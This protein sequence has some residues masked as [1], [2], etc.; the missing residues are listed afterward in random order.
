MV[1]SKLDSV[2]GE[3]PHRAL[4][5]AGTHLH[6][7]GHVCCGAGPAWRASLGISASSSCCSC[8]ELCSWSPQSEQLSTTPLHRAV[9]T[10]EQETVDGDHGLRPLR[11]WAR[12]PTSYSKVLW[13]VW[14]PSCGKLANT[15]GSPRKG[16]TD[17]HCTLRTSRDHNT[18][19]SPT[20]VLTG[21]G[22]R[23]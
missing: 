10:S 3:K 16:H 11:P 22:T 8:S 12:S 7:H 1:T 23:P 21:S 15:A 18:E 13:Q 9:S 5:L 17:T 20:L 6:V 19:P 2:A 4:Y 14:H